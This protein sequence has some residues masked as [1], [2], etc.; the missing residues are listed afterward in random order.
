MAADVKKKFLT[1]LSISE[2]KLN[3]YFINILLGQRKIKLLREKRVAIE[4]ERR[5]TSEVK[6]L[7]A[8]VLLISSV[9][10]DNNKTAIGI[11]NAIIS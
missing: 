10:E 1:L 9:T 4:M 11:F 7:I 3:C 2:N 8:R 6:P 5:T